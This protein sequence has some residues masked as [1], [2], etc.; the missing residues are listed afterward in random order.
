MSSRSCF[1]FLFLAVLLLPAMGM[2]QQSPRTAASTG[3]GATA[4]SS[5]APV[6]APGQGDAALT[7]QERLRVL[8]GE[9]VLEVGQRILLGLLLFLAGWIVA[10]LVA[11]A[12]YRLLCKTTIDDRIAHKLG[13]DM[14]TA[15]SE[16]TSDQVE[17]FTARV[18]YYLLMMLVVVGVLQYAGLS[19]AAGPIESFVGKITAALPLVGKAILILVVAYFGGII[20]QKLVTRFID[21]AKLDQRFAELNA[22]PSQDGDDPDAAGRPFSQ[23]AGRVVFWLIMV[24]GLAGAVDALQ[25]GPLAHSLRNA[26]DRIVALLPAVAIA[27]ALLVGGYVLGRIVRAVLDNLLDTVGFNKLVARAGL[28]QVFGETRASHAVGWVAMAFVILQAAIAALNE[29]GLDTLSTPLTT[30]MTRF[31]SFLPMLAVSG[32]ILAAGTIGGRLLRGV[33]ERGLVN[34]KFDDAMGRLGFGRL[35]EREGRLATPHQVVGFIV[36]IGVVLLATVQ[37]LESMGLSTWAAYVHGFIAYSVTHVAVALVIVAVGMAIGNYVRDLIAMRRRDDDDEAVGWI[38]AFARYAVLVF[39]FTMAIHHLD[40][41]PNFV[42]IAFSLL[43]GSLC[44]AL[45]L[46]LGLGAR[47]VA[48]DL[49]RRQYNKARSELES[50]DAQ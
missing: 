13:V 26:V 43:F 28:D 46:A 11:W 34:L 45:A 25:I 9:D 3:T 42:L 47:E 21:S 2:A 22:P 36:Q 15:E 6:T 10:K 39:A 38:A 16:Q 23:T 41:G 17:R 48:G 1:L 20:L 30:M 24:A 37:A 8:I 4:S 40:I 19:Q 32:L 50:R 18:V 12:T 7:W 35:Q 44:L 49:V 14:L 33:V 5:T 29:L 27:G 31:W